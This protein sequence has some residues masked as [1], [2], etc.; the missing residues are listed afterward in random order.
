MA[1]GKVHALATFVTAPNGIMQMPSDMAGFAWGL[2]CIVGLLVTND[3]DLLE[4]SGNYSLYIIRET[5]GR[6]SPPI[7]K[8]WVFYWYPY[9]K[10][11]A[12]RSWQSHMPVVS[13]LIRLLYM[14][15][16]TAIIWYALGSNFQYYVLA[17]ICTD[18]VHTILDAKIW[19]LLRLFSQ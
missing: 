2:G 14:L 6:L 11:L 8:A 16:F 10:T 9:S 5:F 15:P 12:H 7:E 13:T 17:L 1:S 18:T 4:S 3:L 19:R